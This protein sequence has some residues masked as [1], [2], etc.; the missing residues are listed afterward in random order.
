LSGG[1]PPR[2]GAPLPGGAVHLEL[3]L[4]TATGP[5]RGR[6]AVPLAPMRLADLVPQALELADQLSA[7]AAIRD[8]RDGHAVSCRAGCGACCKQMVPLSVPE[9]FHL[10]EQVEVLP[11]RRRAFIEERFRQARERVERSDIAEALLA[12]PYDELAAMGAA[13]PYFRL[14]VDCPFLEDQS[15]SAYADRP[16]ICRQ[17][18]VTTP[19]AWC[20]DPDRHP[21]RQ[22][23]IPTPVSRPLARVAA[24]LTGA[25]PRLVPL[26]LALRWAE[27]HRE[28][29]A[30]TWPGPV[31]F[32]AFLR[33][34]GAP[35]AASPSSQGAPGVAK[36]GE[37]E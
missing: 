16:T 11:P 9:V 7:R 20:V 36:A 37:A 2:S 3:E 4:R 1:A 30:R 8:S 6:V 13:L 14:G 10:A 32:E 17:Y 27:E 26:T 19:A 29:G 12:E 22:I 5:L 15:C 21:V 24:E 18:V 31:L 25:S 33:Y 28:L 23:P 35:P 34:L